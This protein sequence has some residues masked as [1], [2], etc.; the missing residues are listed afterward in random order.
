[1]TTS[2]INTS[3]PVLHIVVIGFHHKKGCQ[4]DYAFPPLVPGGTVDSHETPAE[5]KHLPSLAIP[6]G[7]H[8][9]TQDSIYFHLPGLDDRHRTV[10]GVACYRQIETKDLKIKTDDIT[11]ST[12]QKSVCVLS[13]LP[14]YGLIEAKLELITHAYF[15]EL[16]FRQV[17]LLEDT[18]NNLNASLRESLLDGGSQVF[19]GMNIK[20]LVQTY[21]HRVMTLFKLVLLDEKG[22]VHWVLFTGSPVERLA[23]TM[24]TILSLYPGMIEQGLAECTSYGG[25]R[26][27]SPTL[28]HTGVGEEAEEFL[29]IR[30]T[31]DL[32]PDISGLSGTDS[33]EAVEP[34]SPT[35]DRGLDQPSFPMNAAESLKISTTSQALGE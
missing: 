14:L 6:D 2:A 29:E 32:S 23:N 9:Y 7:A 5:W 28:R 8:N 12:V 13:N 24:L 18:Y 30:Y 34:A 11:R 1:M 10:Y 4:V 3:K 15:L 33:V 16:D 19:L 35:I 26:N 25:D 31:G 17:S 20:E 21:R 27:I 22:F